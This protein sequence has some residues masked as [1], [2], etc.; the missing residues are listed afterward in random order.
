MYDAL[1]YPPSSIWNS[2][3]A[4]I[5]GSEKVKNGLSM[6]LVAYYDKQKHE[7]P[8]QAPTRA[9]GDW[10]GSGRRNLST[11]GSCN[12]RNLPFCIILVV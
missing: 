9:D 12:A 2:F 10:L 4:A 8:E 5:G 1:P 7:P 6:N 11:L 3:L